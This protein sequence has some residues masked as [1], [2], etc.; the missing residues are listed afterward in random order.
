MLQASPQTWREKSVHERKHNLLKPRGHAPL[1]KQLWPAGLAGTQ[2]ANELQTDPLPQSSAAGIATCQL[3]MYICATLSRCC[4]P[5]TQHA[6]PANCVSCTWTNVERHYMLFQAA[7]HFIGAL[8][9]VCEG[10]CMVMS[11]LMSHM[12]RPHTWGLGRY[13][14]RTHRWGTCI[15]W[16]NLLQMQ[17]TI[18]L[19]RRMTR[20]RVPQEQISVMPSID[21]HS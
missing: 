20:E 3:R 13:S 6:A 19:T 2:T 17:Y 18:A 12:D 5:T 21:K 14:C 7:L 16:R 10:P 8:S 1:S 4:D 9:M 11:H 15:C